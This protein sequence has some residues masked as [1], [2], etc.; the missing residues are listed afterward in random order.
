MKDELLLKQLQAELAS[1]WSS[2]PAPSK[3]TKSTLSYRSTPKINADRKIAKVVNTEMSNIS[4]Q[5]N[6]ERRSSGTDISNFSLKNVSSVFSLV[7]IPVSLR[8]FTASISHLHQFHVEKLVKLNPTHFSRSNHD[9]LERLKLCILKKQTTNTTRTEEKETSQRE[10]SERFA[11][12]A[13]GAN[14]VEI[15][16]T[17]TSTEDNK[18]KTIKDMSDHSA[19][20]GKESD[21]YI[22]KL[23]DQDVN[24]TTPLRSITFPNELTSLKCI[25]LDYFPNITVGELSSVNLSTLAQVSINSDTLRNCELN[26]IKRFCRNR[27]K[28]SKRIISE[29]YKSSHRGKIA[30]QPKIINEI[31]K[32]KK[33]GASSDKDHRF[34]IKELNDQVFNRE[35]LLCDIKL[36]HTLVKVGKDI[37]E[38]F[39]DTKVIDFITSEREYE[40]INRFDLYRLKEFC[41]RRFEGVD[42]LIEMASQEKTEAP[43]ILEEKTKSNVKPDLKETTSNSGINSH[44]VPRFTRETP[45]DDVEIPNELQKVKEQVELHLGLFPTVGDVLSK[46]NSVFNGISKNLVLALKEFYSSGLAYSA[47]DTSKITFD[48]DS[49]NS[50]NMNSSDVNKL[51]SEREFRV[52]KKL[53]PSSIS[54]IRAKVNTEAKLKDVSSKPTETLPSSIDDIDMITSSLFGMGNM[55]T[56]ITK[57]GRTLNGW[58]RQDITRDEAFS[59]DEYS[60][61][62]GGGWFIRDKHE[63]SLANLLRIRNGKLTKINVDELKERSQVIESQPDAE[64]MK[65]CEGQQERIGSAVIIDERPKLDLEL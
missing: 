10:E 43:V 21:K 5:L 14:Q 23:N 3:A 51:D 29:S 4:Q 27:L 9:R 38:S 7:D 26:A 42:E 52:E 12:Y 45:L 17:T 50:D 28:K 40:K 54:H 58:V 41:K 22:Q 47:T 11:F 48:V 37:L 44:V 16:N 35:A 8:G 63:T 34:S 30:S 55:V 39:P 64:I 49:S 32:A 61:R 1:G 65:M 13:Q 15:L 60:F 24:V 56:H 59:I 2:V 46:H 19:V 33:S 53:E 57:R 20:D 6:K 31:T 62:K 25:L 36:P 18:T